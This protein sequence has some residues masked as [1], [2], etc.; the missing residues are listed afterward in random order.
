[1]AAGRE[2]STTGFG[3]GGRRARRTRFRI[4]LRGVEIPDDAA[5]DPSLHLYR[6]QSLSEYDE[7]MQRVIERCSA[8]PDLDIDLDEARSVWQDALTLP[9]DPSSHHWY[10][11]DLVAENL[12]VEGGRLTGVLDFGGLGV[13][14]PTIDLH[15]AWELFDPSA[16]DVFRSRLQIDDTEWLRGRA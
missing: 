14:D 16:R 9:A 15:G 12:L 10:H 2:F 8:I 6:G 5:T 3:T 13:G 11:G 7:E 1:M 4:E